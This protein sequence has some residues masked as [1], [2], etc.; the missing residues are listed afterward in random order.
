MPGTTGAILSS[1]HGFFPYSHRGELRQAKAEDSRGAAPQQEWA[2]RSPLVKCSQQLSSLYGSKAHRDF[3][4]QHALL[5]L[6]LSG[7]MLTLHA[8]RAPVRKWELLSG[9][10][11]TGEVLPGCP[12]SPLLCRL[13]NAGFTV[14]ALYPVGV[15]SLN[16]MIL[17]S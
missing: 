8:S 7:R 5:H 14:A 6:D 9:W 16:T 12:C 15:G 10:F 11:C 13:S 1:V 2:K 3:N 4:S 17:F